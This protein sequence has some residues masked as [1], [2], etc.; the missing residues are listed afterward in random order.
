MRATRA[1]QLLLGAPGTQAWR[2][3]HLPTW[4]VDV[5]EHQVKLGP[6]PAQQLQRRGGVWA[7][8]D[9]GAG[10]CVS[11]VPGASRGNG[12]SASVPTLIAATPQHLL[13]DLEAQRV[14]VDLR[15][16]CQPG[17]VASNYKNGVLWGA[18]R[19]SAALERRPAMQCQALQAAGSAAA[20]QGMPLS[21]AAW[22][23]EYARGAQGAAP[24]SSALSLPRRPSALQ[25]SQTAGCRSEYVPSWLQASF[26]W[27]Q[28]PLAAAAAPC[29]PLEAR[30]SPG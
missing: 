28:R 6:P 22:E 23:T 21:Q 10:A 25:E 18:S 30:E 29:C 15:W 16:R 5:G 1:G 7:R 8:R 11:L 14:V 12:A 2:Q 4:H 19:R 9:C 3:C 17:L 27:P 13:D 24:V 26:P 20:Q